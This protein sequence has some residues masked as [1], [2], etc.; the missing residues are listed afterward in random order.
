MARSRVSSLV[1]LVAMAVTSCTSGPGAGPSTDASSPMS[2]THRVIV[3]FTTTGPES[4]PPTAIL[5]LGDETVKGTAGSYCW[6]T[7]N[8]E[9]CVDKVAP[10]FSDFLVVPRGSELLV[11]GTAESV[12]GS[13][14]KTWDQP[15]V[16]LDLARGSATLDAEPAKYVLSFVAH[17]PQGDVPFFFAVEIVPSTEVP[18]PS[19]PRAEGLDATYA[20]PSG[21]SMRYPEGWHLTEFENVCMAGFTGAL[22]AN[23]TDAYHSPVSESGCY[24]PPRMNLLP[25]TGVVV[26]FDLM[27]GGPGFPA[28]P[29]TPDT[30]FPLSFDDLQ[31]VPTPGPGPVMYSELVQ[32]NGMDRYHLDVWIGPEAST[33]DQEIARQI[34][35]SIAFGPSGSTTPSPP[36]QV[37]EGRCVRST[38]TGDFDGDGAPD[39]ATLYDVPPAGRTC[40]QDLSGHLRLGVRFGSG[41]RFDVPFTYCGGGACDTVFTAVDLDANGRSELV[42]EVGPGAAVDSI[43][44]FRVLADGIRPLQIAPPG[45]PGYVEPGPAIFGGG[46]DSGQQSPVACEVGP[47]GT[48]RLVSI[49]A[50]PTGD[51][52]TAPWHVHRTVLVL[53]GDTFTVVAHSDSTV[54]RFPFRGLTFSCP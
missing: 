9:R 34:V 8:A 29:T 5:V 2:S 22:V 18:S 53:H 36:E 48:R 20:D 54:T 35:S 43:E 25:P 12:D 51:L 13:L 38:T 40:H 6:S 23:V 28:T 52:N 44:F 46:F 24:W 42:V 39:R 17:W 21:W 1:A 41:G 37:T 11:R 45:D 27:E 49:H 50:A 26:E 15:G 16:K 33:E 19:S 30:T 47:D 31:V 4:E 32:V 3:A 14:G 10:E 7:G